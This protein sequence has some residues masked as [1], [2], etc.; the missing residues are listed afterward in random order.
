MRVRPGDYRIAGMYF[1]VEDN[2]DNVED[3]HET[4]PP[5]FF[6]NDWHHFMY[7]K[8]A[9]AET[10][11]GSGTCLPGGETEELRCITLQISDDEGNLT[12]D[13]ND[14]EAVVV[15]AGSQVDSQD[16]TTLAAITDYFE[17]RNNQSGNDIVVRAEHRD[18][19]NDRV[20]V[21]WPNPG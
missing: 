4:F 19:Y 18:D 1:D 13:R 16:R 12:N 14:A 6:A 7:V 21:V 20:R 8:V 9:K 15:I 2:D 17:N 10:A 5:W 3:S 11:D